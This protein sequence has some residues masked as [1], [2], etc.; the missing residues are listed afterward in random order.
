MDPDILYV[1]WLDHVNSKG[2]PKDSTAG[3]LSHYCTVA[4]YVG[5]FVIMAVIGSHIM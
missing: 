5:R 1:A 3:D 2:V 4:K